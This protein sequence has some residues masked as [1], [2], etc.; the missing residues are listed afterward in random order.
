MKKLIV[1][2]TVLSVSKKDKFFL[3][4]LISTAAWLNAHDEKESNKLRGNGKLSLL[5]VFF[6]GA[7][8]CINSFD[9]DTVSS[10]SIE[11]SNERDKVEIT[12]TNEFIEDRIVI[13]TVTEA[14]FLIAMK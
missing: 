9:A 7:E 12:S 5:E 2:G 10:I 6:R 14:P 1:V 4:H 8:D 3:D 11:I 13:L